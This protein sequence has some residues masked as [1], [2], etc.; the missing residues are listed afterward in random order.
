VENTSDPLLTPDAL[1]GELAS[2][3]PP[4]VL[5]LRPAEV[6][7]RGHITGAIHLDLWGVSLIDTSEAPLRAFMWMIGHLFSL[8]GVTP[9]RAVV[10]YE[11]ESG[12]RAARAFWFLEYLGHPSVRLLDGGIRAWAAA[13]FPLTTNTVTPVPSHW[14]GDANPA[15]LATWRQVYERLGDV[16]SV[17]VDTRSDGEHR[18]TVVRARR[19]GAIPGAVH[20]EWTQ[21]LDEDGRYKPAADLRKMYVKAG[22]TPDREVITYCQ[23]GYRAAHTYLALRVLG[24]P[25]VRNYTGSWKEWGDREDL[26]IA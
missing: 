25:H 13:G 20:L 5:D 11:E 24:Y 16:R 26:P 17:I 4:L 18:G 12:I 3:R 2:A 6:F 15:R 22:V 23:G 7:A 21:N 1:A 14:H 10:V 9:D 8:R 19:G